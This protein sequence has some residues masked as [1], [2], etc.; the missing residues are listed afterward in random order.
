MRMRVKKG[1]AV[2]VLQFFR[3]MAEEIRDANIMGLI[4]EQRGTLIRFLL[5]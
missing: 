5:F 1:L 3:E 4:K 2:V